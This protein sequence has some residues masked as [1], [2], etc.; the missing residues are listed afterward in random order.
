LAG[1]NY[2]CLAFIRPFS[3]SWRRLHAHAFYLYFILI[4][5][6]KAASNAYKSVL[7]MVV[8]FLILSYLFHAPKLAMGACG[9][10]VAALLHSTICNFIVLAWEKLGHALG[11]LNSK[12]LLSLIYF[13]ILLPLALLRKLFTG[14]VKEANTNFYDRNVEYTAT[15]L[16]NKW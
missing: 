9:L 7:T 3:G 14:K 16:Q 6:K 11:W 4:A 1:A 13:I 15:H 12:V 10:G 2:Y 8:G 5:M